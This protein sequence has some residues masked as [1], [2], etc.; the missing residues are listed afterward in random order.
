MVNDD[1]AAFERLKKDLAHH[2]NEPGKESKFPRR[3]TSITKILWNFTEAE[4]IIRNLIQ[5]KRYFMNEETNL[6]P[7]RKNGPSL[8]LQK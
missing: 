3:R 7:S 4:K 1:A 5:K 6:G 2:F 8:V